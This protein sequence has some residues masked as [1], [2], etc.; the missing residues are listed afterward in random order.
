MIDNLI[1]NGFFI[2]QRFE[3]PYMFPDLTMLTWFLKHRWNLRHLRR[4][5][6]LFAK[7]YRRTALKNYPRW[8]DINHS[9]ISL[10]LSW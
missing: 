2:Q 10:L 8:I 3:K 7:K 1:R 5:K 9:L 6:R 4:K